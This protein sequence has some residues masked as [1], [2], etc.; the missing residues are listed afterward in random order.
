ML[1]RNY[2]DVAVDIIEKLDTKGKV[3]PYQVKYP[4]Y[5]MYG[6]GKY[7]IGNLVN[8]YV[9]LEEL[10]NN[11]QNKPYGDRRVYSCFRL[12]TVV[13]RNDGKTSGENQVDEFGPLEMTMER[14]F[15]H[16]T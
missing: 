12:Y 14:L 8:E 9:K 15:G 6:A 3:M 5:E 7:C 10:Y 13:K 11:M 16:L 2:P 4:M 1:I